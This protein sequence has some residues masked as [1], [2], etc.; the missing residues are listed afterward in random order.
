MIHRSFRKQRL[1]NHDLTAM[2]AGFTGASISE[3]GGQRITKKGSSRILMSYDWL[4]RDFP[5]IYVLWSSQSMMEA[6][7]TAISF[8]DLA[9]ITMLAGLI[10]LY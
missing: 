9:V 2:S 10:F 6:A 5:G 1:T 4:P 3:I 7:V 8:L